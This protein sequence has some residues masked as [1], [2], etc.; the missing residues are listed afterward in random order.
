MLLRTRHVG[1]RFVLTWREMGGPP[2]RS[3]PVR[4][5]F[6]ANL[7]TLSVEGQLGGRLERRW[8]SEGLEVE[9]D[10]P[11][12]ALSRRRAALRSA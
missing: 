11:E 9:A 4:T 10:L 1:D 12:T 7:A 3:E 2:I 6:G 8:L 5:G